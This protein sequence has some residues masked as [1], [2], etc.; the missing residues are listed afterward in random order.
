M[1]ENDDSVWQKCNAKIKYKTVFMVNRRI[2]VHW[3][4]KEMYNWI[5]VIKK[6]KKQYEKDPLLLPQ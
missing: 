3:K 2:S 4:E 5:E 6:K 1:F